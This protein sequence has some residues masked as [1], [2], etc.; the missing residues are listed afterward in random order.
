MLAKSKIICLFREVKL[1][2]DATSK[3]KKLQIRSYLATFLIISQGGASRLRHHAG[4]WC[5]S[6]IRRTAPIA[7]EKRN[8][9]ATGGAHLPTPPPVSASRIAA[10]LEFFFFRWKD[11]MAIFVNL[12][13]CQNLPKIEYSILEIKVFFC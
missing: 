10:K 2:R 9:P 1:E 6:C 3:E 12:A 7:K 13:L 5:C 4:C 8:L 11:H